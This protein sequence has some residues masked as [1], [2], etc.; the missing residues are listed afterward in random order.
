MPPCILRLEPDGC[1]IAVEV[2]DRA[3]KA[4]VLKVRACAFTIQYFHFT[5]K[6]LA[7]KGLIHM[8]SPTSCLQ[9]QMST[10]VFRRHL[11]ESSKG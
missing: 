2:E 1:Q 3:D 4:S 9:S 6:V 10:R 5:H 7:F 8:F 11:R